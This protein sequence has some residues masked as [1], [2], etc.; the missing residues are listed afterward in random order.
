MTTFSKRFAHL[1]MTAATFSI[2]MS[3]GAFAQEKA[4]QVGSVLDIDGKILMT[5]RLQE[6]TWYQAYPA[7]KTYLKERMKTDEDT[8]ATIEFLVGGRAVIAP[9]TEVEIT[10][11]KDTTI[12]NIKSG[13]VWAKFD[14]QDKEF[15]IQT[16]GGVMGIEGTEFIVGVDDKTGETEL[17]VIEGAV[18]VNNDDSSQLIPGGETANF[19]QKSLRVAEYIALTSPEAAIRD[20]AFSRMDPELRNR[21]QPVVNRSLRLSLIHI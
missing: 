12:L 10:T 15:Q 3:G 16:A 1:A 17:T 19:G 8:T 14:K 2:L 21:V 6:M 11:P 4:K 18:R 20:A 7:M 9:G 5:N 13:S